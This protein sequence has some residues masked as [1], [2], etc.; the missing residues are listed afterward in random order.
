MHPIRDI[1]SIKGLSERVHLPRLGKIRLGIRQPGSNG[2]SA[3]TEVPHF[4]CPPRVQRVYGAA[5]TALP[6]LFPVEDARE[7]FPQAYKWYGG[8]TLKCK[9]DGQVGLRRWADVEPAL[10]GKIGGTHEPNDLV[11]VACPCPRL[12]SGD[13]TLKANLMYLLPDISLAGVWQTDTQSV[14]N[15]R[16]IN[17]ALRFYRELLGRIALVPFTLHR[18]PTK[19]RWQGKLVTHHLLK[20]TYDGDL[21]AAQAI[22]ATAPTVMGPVT[23][24][25]SSTS[26]GNGNSTAA[27]APVPAQPNTDAAPQ[28]PN[29]QPVAGAPTPADAPNEVL[30]PPAATPALPP[31][32]P[33]AAPASTVATSPSAGSEAALTPTTPSSPPTPASRSAGSPRCPCGVRVTP[34]IAEYSQRYFGQTLCITCQKRRHGAS[35]GATP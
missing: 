6:I 8:P 16:E 33:T 19:V 17:S 5:P 1:R 27:S 3:P 24:L 9:G 2:A 20:L 14:H 18:E 11:E 32:I 21:S 25:P 35:Q 10:Q 30:A 13:C 22:R 12:T 29:P 34:R 31:G 4:V 23:P 15:I 26:P 28:Q 7:L